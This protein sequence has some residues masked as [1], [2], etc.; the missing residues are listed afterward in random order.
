MVDDKPCISRRHEES[1]GTPVTTVFVRQGHYA[2]DA[3]IPADYPP[4]V[5]GLA[6]IVDLLDL[7]RTHIILGR[8]RN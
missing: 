7:D 5:P 1:L 2:L 3:K 8:R 6:R 4:A